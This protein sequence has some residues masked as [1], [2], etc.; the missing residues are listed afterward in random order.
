[1]FAGSGYGK[2]YPVLNRA[3]VSLYW[4]LRPDSTIVRGSTLRLNPMDA[5]SLSQDLLV[6]GEFEPFETELF[7]NVI[8]DRDVIFDVGANIGYY[9]VMASSASKS[10][11]VFAFEPDE[12]NFR[13]LERNLRDN[14]CLNVRCFQVAVSDRDGPVLLYKCAGN[15]GDH[16]IYPVAG[17]RSTSVEAI[18]LDRF[19]PLE[20]PAPRV[21]KID[22]QGAEPQA[23]R[24]MSRVIR[25]SP[26]LALFT[27]F[28]PEGLAAAGSSAEEY[29][30]L[31]LSHEFS[32][33]AIIEGARRL[34]PIASAAE[35]SPYLGTYGEANLLC[36]KGSR[37]LWGNYLPV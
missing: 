12:V 20:V 26:E 10:S 35:V 7:I 11:S 3:F 19:L 28:W 14:G 31:L 21:V 18:T 2:R 8:E 30:S 36:L 29:F 22:I 15:E 6:K 13:L 5:G 25:A 17:R 33:Y 34:E 27:E 1:M 37:A 32:V 24:G 16:R 4:W 9:S 23:L